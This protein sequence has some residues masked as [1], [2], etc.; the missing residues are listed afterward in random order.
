M[1]K[2]GKGTVKGRSHVRAFTLVAVITAALAPALMWLQKNKTEHASTGFGYTAEFAYPYENKAGG[3]TNFDLENQVAV[4]GVAN[5]SCGAECRQDLLEAMKGVQG[6]S[7]EHLAGRNETYVLPVKYYFMAEELP[8]I[9]AEWGGFVLSEKVAALL[10][11]RN[12]E[13]TSHPALIAVI[14]NTGLYRNI[15]S[16]QDQQGLET[17][18]RELSKI[19][20]HSSLIN[21][22]A[23]QTLMWE[24][25]RGRA[26]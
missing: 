5:S 1:G 12:E 21:Y 23:E 18:K 16:P 19:I 10:P 26:K 14:D 8:K 24:K 7:E 13:L 9:P 22:V 2:F 4:V 3:L 6:W 11:E 17:I 25:A 15:V 20:S